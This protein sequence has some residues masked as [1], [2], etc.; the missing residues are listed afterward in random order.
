MLLSCKIILSYV[1][2]VVSIWRIMIYSG[3]IEIIFE[4]IRETM[5]K[6]M[7]SLSNSKRKNQAIDQ[8]VNFWWFN[9]GKQIPFTIF[10]KSGTF[11][12]SRIA[13]IL[14]KL[15]AII[16]GPKETVDFDSVLPSHS[17]THSTGSLPMK[18]A[19]AIVDDF[20]LSNMMFLY[21]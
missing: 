21:W 9:I 5:L 4:R 11:A 20:R 15:Y 17:Q 19:I 7:Q 1:I 8:S 18:A 10:F 2:F 16:D 12:S 13:L 3:T 6:T 14:E